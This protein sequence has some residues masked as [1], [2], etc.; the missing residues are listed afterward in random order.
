M[1]FGDDNDLNSEDVSEGIDQFADRLSNPGI[2]LKAILTLAIVNAVIWVLAIIYPNW[3][4]SILNPFSGAS[5]HS[6]PLPTL[7][8]FITG[9]A[10]AFSIVRYF[11]PLAGGYQNAASD[12][13][14]LTA[15]FAATES[16]QKIWFIAAGA[17]ILNLLAL[18]V[19]SSR[20]G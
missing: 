17:G 10:L 16:R 4:H 15:Q 6:N 19:V 13:P 2:A 3:L 12:E 11:R 18:L 8:P 5:E 14:D 20:L 1:A 9:G 7:V